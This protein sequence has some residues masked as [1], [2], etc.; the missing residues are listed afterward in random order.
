MD[1]IL[2]LEVFKR[3]D[4]T[5]QKCFGSK[6]EGFMLHVEQTKN[7]H[8]H[9]KYKT[10]QSVS[11]HID[12]LVTVCDSCHKGEDNRITSKHPRNIWI[13]ESTREELNKMASS[14][15]ATYNDVILALIDFWNKNS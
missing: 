1:E 15:C 7:L 8:A 2:R 9:H 10:P 11:E 13:E 14:R 5:C 6:Q 4:F 12:D 3:D